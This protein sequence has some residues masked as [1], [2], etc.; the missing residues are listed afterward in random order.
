[1]TRVSRLPQDDATC[2]WYAMLPP[3]APAR[4]LEGRESADWA[5]LGAGL[6]GLAAAR[7]LAGHLPNARIALIEAERVGFGASGRN[8]G[9]AID[10][11]H[12]VV[13]GN[14]VHGRARARDT[15]LEEQR[16]RRRLSQ[17][18]VA[19]LRGLIES[20]GID[21]AWRELG[22][23]HGAV[24][25]GGLRALEDYARG[26]DALEAPYEWLNQDQMQA[27]TGTGYY[28]K[29]LKTPGTAL[30]QPAAL[31]RGLAASLPENVELFEESPVIAWRIGEAIELECAEGA[32]VTKGL[33]LATN[34]FTPAIGF[35]K[36]RFFPVFTF[37]SLTRPLG[38]DEQAA[39]GGEPEWGLIAGDR[40]GT[41]VRRTG[42]QRI[43]IRNTFLYAPRLHFGEGELARLR[44]LH[45]RSFGARF[46]MLGEVAFD[47]SWGGALCMSSNHALF[48]G[49]LA[50]GIFAA[51]GCNGAGVAM[52]TISGA[53]LADYVV[54]AESEL[55]R[56][57]R[58]LPRPKRLPPEPFLG[59]GVGFT[60]K[61]RE[62]RAGKEF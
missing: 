1:M 39:L 26:L 32:L 11:P 8:S 56:D 37:S 25:E 13:H 60:L 34:A 21:C 57:I 29:G 6:T 27:V 3:P 31:T 41:T 53:L 36:D 2:G 5:V 48:F 15:L 4:R 49:A 14:V 47:Y 50:P 22:K 19:A 23:L 46:P 55:L 58:A 30:M 38:R 18:G 10:L 45:R 7:R 61:R 24:E 40:L 62:R 51:V 35:L 44:G 42:D 16:R 33:L 52:G 12:S 54:G 43:L 9:F 17:A 59:L 28:R 20:H